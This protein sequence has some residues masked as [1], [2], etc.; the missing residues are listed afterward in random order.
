M[1]YHV[2]LILHITAGDAVEDDSK[3]S[4]VASNTALR[5]CQVCQED[6]IVAVY[7][8]PQCPSSAEQYFCVECDKEIHSRGQRARHNRVCISMQFLDFFSQTCSVFF[9]D[10]FVFA[11]SFDEATSDQFLQR[12]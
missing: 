6:R 5:L 9:I 8:C 10:N 7:H 4:A 1:R 3:T 11:S 12:A 2:V